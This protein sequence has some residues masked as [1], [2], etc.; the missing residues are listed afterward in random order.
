MR[1]IPGDT[2]IETLPDL[3]VLV[4]RDGV[5]LASGGGHGVAALRPVRQVAGERLEALWSEPVGA[6]LRQLTRKVI[7]A[8]TGAEARFEHEGR[9]YE[10]R[11]S[12]QGPD[13]AVCIIREAPGEL[14][15][16]TADTGERPQPHLDRR[17]FLK[18]FKESMALAAL[19]ETPIA[20]AVIH[21]DGIADIAQV[22]AVTVSEQVMSAAIRHLPSPAAEATA[23]KPWWYLGQLSESLLAL[24]LESD[25]RDTLDGC[26]SQVCA[27]LREP[28]HSGGA[29][30]HLTPYA[31]VAILGQDASA[32]QTLLDHA[33]AAAAE[34]RRSARAT[35]RFFSDTVKLRTLARLD[36]AR[37]LR[38]AIAHGGFRLRYLGRYDLGSGRRVAHVGYLRWL[39]PLRG[40]I[41]PSE[42][43]RVAETTGLAVPLSRA[44]LA[45]LREDCIALAT[46]EHPDVRISFGPLRHHVLHEGFAADITRFLVDT[47]VPPERLEL[48]IAEKTFIA[49]DPRQ[50]VRI[51]EL[52]V[53]LVVDEVGRGMG[54]LDWLARAPIWGLQLDR[55]WVTALR[56]DAVAR[57]VCGAG[58]AMAGALG[59]TPI[60]TGVDDREQ[61][62]AL[63]ALGCQY[64]SGDLYLDATSD[65]AS[66]TEASHGTEAS[67]Q[68]ASA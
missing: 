55:A 35:V 12:A 27:S 57:K 39:H 47:S 19:R 67:R 62:E 50:L 2:L 9:S 59:L 44:V 41:R 26:V 36:M 7:A 23:E 68:V 43:L 65:G 33:R 37:E 25:N 46:G 10:V 34:A 61:R 4:R 16:D 6:L 28:I 48:R 14:R 66:D 20:V 49:Q 60:A 64:G 42:F 15:T 3:I 45:C 32:P 8:R 11:A 5:V 21:V 13:R 63:L 1:V 58:I 51:S 29:E 17:G 18:R 30:F 31:G 38:E 56:N 22:L 24:V 53:R 54:S 40:E 52:G